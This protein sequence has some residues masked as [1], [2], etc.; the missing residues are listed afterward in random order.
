[1]LW[2]LD[3]T[4]IDTEPFWFAAEHDL[5]RSFGGSWSD[6]HAL[7]LVGSDLLSAGRYIRDTAGVDLEP[8]AIVER[9]VANVN[10][11]LRTEIPWRPG[12]RALLASLRSAG[13]PCALVTMSYRSLT[14]P[15]VDGL[16]ADTFA[17]I[18]T[19]DSVT[20]GKP[21]PEPYLTAARLLGFDPE[22][23]VA[24]EDSDTGARS[25]SAAGCHVLAVP[26][27]TSIEAGPGRTF[28]S[29]LEGVTV[30]FLGGL[31]A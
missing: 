12:A 13:V 1:M 6:E 18:V 3:G 17:A 8:A 16:P 11:R 7:A 4:I 28:A 2:D 24:I 30:E 9:L 29:T 26:G 22:A 20:H 27:H 5:V 31:V 14:V 10:E 19:G 25:A 15:I 23:C 21:H